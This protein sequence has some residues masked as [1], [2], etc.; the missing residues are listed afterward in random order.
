[1]ALAKSPGVPGDPLQDV[2]RASERLTARSR[3]TDAARD[4]LR[5]RI[6]AAA[7]AGCSMSSIAR[8][9]GVSRQWVA[10]LLARR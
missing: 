2:R 8:A 3:A 1:M 6:Y 5:T 10:M 7:D 9:A 4:E